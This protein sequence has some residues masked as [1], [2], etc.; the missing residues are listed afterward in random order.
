MDFGEMPC[1]KK[2]P[3]L[4]EVEEHEID[5]R[6][7]TELVEIIG[8]DEGEVKEVLT[9][10]GER[11]ACGFLG[12]TT[13]VKPNVDF[14]DE[15]GL[16]IHKGVLVDE[17]FRTNI[18]NVYAIGDCAEFLRPPAADRGCIEKV[19]YTGRMHGE[20]LAHTLTKKPVAYQPGPWFNSAKGFG[21]SELRL[22]ACQRS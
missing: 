15:S 10:S 6:L 2:S 5:L 14:L 1:P 11:I 16:N 9:S 12:L 21:V 19:W 18:E 13:G 17:Y 8:N 7:N 22:G 3:N 20:T 4:S